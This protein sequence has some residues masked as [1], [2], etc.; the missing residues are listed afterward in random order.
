MCQFSGAAA[1]ELESRR[2]RRRSKLLVG[3]TF[4][5]TF[6]TVRA[7]S[8][9]ASGRLRPRA[10]S[11]RHDHSGCA[12]SAFAL[13]RAARY[14]PG[15]LRWFREGFYVGLTIALGVGLL[16]LWVWRPERQIC[17]HSEHLLRA[18]EHKNWTRVSDFIAVDYQDQWGHDRAR[19]LQ[20][21]RAVLRYLRGLRIEA[22][23]VA[24]RTEHRAGY[25]TAAIKI[26][27]EPNELTAAVKERVNA[28]PAPFEL[29]WRRPS[30]KPWDWKLARVSNP[31]LQLPA[32]FDW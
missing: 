1:P 16:L 18:I 7:V 25:W 21:T 23:I 4:D 3:I 17:L 2:L 10:I 26:D 30:K 9:A 8:P 28:L 11:V 31:D 29:E 13:F 19:L 32:E 24:V 5:L 12:E 20:R 15:V 14:N 6:S 27:A 22:S